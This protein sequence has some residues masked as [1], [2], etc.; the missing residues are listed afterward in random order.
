[1]S[2]APPQKNIAYR[3]MV[4]DDE[5]AVLAMAR[6]ILLQA[7]F[8]VIAAPSGEVASA[9]YAEEYMANREIA[10]VILDV[11]LP[12]GMT[13]VETLDAIRRIDPAAKVVASSGYFDEAATSAAEKLGFAAILPKPYTAE[14][15]VKLVEWGV[16]RAA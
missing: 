16:R 2:A 12:G 4:V 15:L 5:S 1:M 10:L 14:S 6:A 8:L 13:G 7:G 11:A 3:V 9:I